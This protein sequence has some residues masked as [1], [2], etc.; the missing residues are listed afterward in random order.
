[1]LG[2]TACA[3]LTAA[4]PISTQLRIARYY[5]PALWRA[6]R[7]RVF[8]RYETGATPSWSTPA[9]ALPNEG[10]RIRGAT[11]R[12]GEMD[13]ALTGLLRASTVTA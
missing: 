12:A 13:R 7:S 1:M 6:E 11:S 9:M 8:R 4:K 10:R 3:K 2:F 5:R